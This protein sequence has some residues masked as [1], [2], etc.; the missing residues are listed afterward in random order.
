MSTFNYNIVN[1]NIATH[2]N[3]TSLRSLLTLRVG[4]SIEVF[5]LHEEFKP[6][7]FSKTLHFG[8]KRCLPLSHASIVQYAI[9]VKLASISELLI[10]GRSNPLPLRLF[11]PV[12]L[13]C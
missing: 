8:V 2:M 11:V 6:S 10:L 13:P 12:Y 5:E 1:T 7:C 3:K 4:R 9:P